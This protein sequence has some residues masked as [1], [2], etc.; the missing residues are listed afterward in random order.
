MFSSV[1]GRSTNSIGFGFL[2]NRFCRTCQRKTTFRTTVDYTYGHVFRIP[3]FRW[4]E[5]YYATCQ[6]CHRSEWLERQSIRSQTKKNPVP[7]MARLGWTVPTGLICVAALVY[8][9]AA[10]SNQSAVTIPQG[11]A[12]LPPAGQ[13]SQEDKAPVGE[14]SDMLSRV[15]PV[16]VRIYTSDSFGS[17]IIV[18][19]AGY[20]LTNNHVVEISNTATVVM[21]DGTRIP[22][23]VIGRD[24]V[25]DLAVLRIGGSGYPAAALGSSSSLLLGED[26]IAVG[27]P[28]GL[29]GTAT[30]S[31]GVVSALRTE[32]GVSYVQTDAAI[33]PGNSGGP[34]VNLS[35]E[36][37][38]INTGVIR[39]VEG[40]PIEG[41]N[42]A[43]A[44]DSA[45]LVL[46]LIPSSASDTPLTTPSS[47]PVRPATGTYIVKELVRGPGE[48]EI[49]N[50][51]HLDAVAVLSL[52]REPAIP[53]MAVY[54]RAGA[55]HT[56]AGIGDG[57][58][59]LYFSSGEHWDDDAKRFVRGAVYQRFEDEFEFQ[60]TLDQCTTWEVTLHPVL[61]G[62]A[63]TDRLDEDEFPS[64]D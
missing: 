43:I 2:D 32:G 25:A 62:E 26:V 1:L 8:S 12:Q 29:E 5:R 20:V 23:S 18:D 9:L 24:E 35:G 41:L 13:A 10:D 50:G 22:A 57:I 53:L 44:I 30:I 36:V 47:V 56:I 39:L 3:L 33:N 7:W 61:G 21:A 55:S 16:V 64:L 60:T 4:K 15:T 59:V 19:A 46:R 14:L 38:G 45:K 28:L 51:L 48:L 27:Y 49:D 63:E 6:S 34:L 52:H 11:V 54:I 40:I 42:F 58:Y 31:T 37:V 17:G